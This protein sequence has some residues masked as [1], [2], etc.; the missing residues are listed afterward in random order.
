MDSARTAQLPTLDR[1][2]SFR[3]WRGEPRTELAEWTSG[4]VRIHWPIESWRHIRLTCQGKLLPLGIRVYGDVEEISAEWPRSGPGRYRFDL[5]HDGSHVV[6]QT[7]TIQP[8]KIGEDAF[9]KLLDD[10]ERSLPVNIAI[11]LQRHGG[12]SGIALLDPRLLTPEQELARLRRAVLG[13]NERPGLADVLRALAVDPH[14]V[15]RTTGF[16]LRA[17]QARRP[18]PSR[19]ISA[20]ARAGNIDQDQHL[21]RIVDD[22]PEQTAETYENR[23][24]KL[25]AEQVSWRLKWL[26]RVLNDRAATQRTNE[27]LQLMENLSQ[28][29]RLASFLDEVRLPSSVSTATTMVLLRR[30]PYLAALT[31]FLEFLRHPAVLF[32]DPKVE[33]PLENLPYLYQSWCTLQVINSILTVTNP[34]GFTLKH[35]Q[36]T[37]EIGGGVYVRVFPN[38]TI[39]M[40]LRN[41][42]T[43]TEI[44][45][46]PERTFGSVGELRSV[47]F[48]QRPDI[49]IEIRR[50]DG[51][52]DL[53][54]L[55]PKYKLDGETQVD[56]E[57]A[58]NP[59][60]A[61]VD[62]MHAYRD[63]IRNRDNVRVV[64]VAA[65]LYP[66]P[67]RAFGP[68]VFAVR[69][70]PGAE[71]ELTSFLDGVLTEALG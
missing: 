40:S 60:K 42:E 59:M 56:E 30:P 55:D 2:V 18:H 14:R 64:K 35:E 16:W 29:R 8:R 24:V 28:A 61:D 25:F 71:R 15:L 36:L 48:E 53:M 41:P 22:R 6:S 68:D 27:P 65:V 45:L 13:T 9:R 54:I 10:L 1:I 52:V 26:D 20:L 62:K 21:L 34:R 4:Y 37:T 19:I 32:D 17:D 44:S 5:W 33:A 63:A 3:D 47:S 70:L 7:E 46:V 69:A 12:L 67:T 39:A 38:G 66:G 58:A 43:G 57:S 23:L 31:G 50:S 51:S 11:G 49:T